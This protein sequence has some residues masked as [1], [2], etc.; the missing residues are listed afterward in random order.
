MSRIQ[1]QGFWNTI[2]S[3]T[4]AAIGVVNLIFLYPFYL[5]TDEIGLIRILTSVSILYA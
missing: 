5:N 2:F 3:Y 1:S 4:G